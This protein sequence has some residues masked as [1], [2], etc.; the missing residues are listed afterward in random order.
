[1]SI[2]CLG[3]REEGGGRREEGGRRKEE[4]GGRREEGEQ[5]VGKNGGKKKTLR[6]NSEK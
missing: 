2:K 3:R 6:G 5:F 4:G 1:L